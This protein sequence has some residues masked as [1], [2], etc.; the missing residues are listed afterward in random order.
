MTSFHYAMTTTP[1]LE[2]DPILPSVSPGL[3][4]LVYSR[5]LHLKMNL[6]LDQPNSFTRL[7]LRIPVFSHVVLGLDHYTLHDP[8]S[9]C[10]P[11]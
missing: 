1:F 11:F 9:V 7:F 10:N 3:L 6:F 2:I 4:Q 5:I 8:T